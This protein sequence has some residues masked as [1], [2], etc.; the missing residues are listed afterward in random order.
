MRPAKRMFQNIQLLWIGHLSCMLLSYTARRAMEVRFEERRPQGRNSTSWMASTLTQRGLSFQLLD[1]GQKEDIE[2]KTMEGFLVLLDTTSSNM[3]Q[4]SG[5][6]M[7]TIEHNY[8][9]F[10]K[11]KYM[12]SIMSNKNKYFPDHI[13][14]PLDCKLKTK[15]NLN[16]ALYVGTFSSTFKMV[17]CFSIYTNIKPLVKSIFFKPPSSD[18]I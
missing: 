8:Y 4:I 11:S 2:R 10:T 13:E 12:C 18:G 7:F 1:D 15:V 17:K 3:I 6:I 9:P 16:F 14:P 5:R